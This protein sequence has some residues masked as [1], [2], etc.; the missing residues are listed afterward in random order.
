MK[1]Y[2]LVEGRRCEPAI[3]RSW[4]EHTFPGMVRVYRPEDAHDDTYLIVS[5]DGYPNY[6]KRIADALGDIADHPGFDHFFV[7]V[8]AEELSFAERMAEVEEVV[9]AEAERTGVLT[10]QPNLRM[11]VIVQDCCVETWLLGHTKMLRRN[12][13]SS[14]LVQMRSFYD[15]SVN[16]P[17]QMG[18]PP[19]YLTRASFH[20]TY[21]Q[22]M[23]REQGKSY[24]KTCPG[25]VQEANYLEALRQRCN[26]T[27]HLGSLQKL[28]S[29]WE[30]IGAPPPALA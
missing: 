1:L 4:I 17:E 21:L 9:R 5:G 20:L 3:Y 14:R 12:P 27:G 26:G 25:I 18:H 29:V 13:H 8:D 2:L 6:L 30:E 24:T 19:G 22:E 28:L 15:V 11:H 23:L 7:C 10:S 16:D